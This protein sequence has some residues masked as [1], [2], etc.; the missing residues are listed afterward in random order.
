MLNARGAGKTVVG[1]VQVGKAI[2]DENNGDQVPPAL[3]CK[4]GCLLFGVGLIVSLLFANIDKRQGL[5]F[6]S[7]HRRTTLFLLL[8][9]SRK[10]QTT[11]VKPPSTNII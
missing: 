8:G 9:V 2:S 11:L 6:D 5:L 4:V 1:T 3:R 10:F 7:I